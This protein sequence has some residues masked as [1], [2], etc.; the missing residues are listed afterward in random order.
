MKTNL[1]INSTDTLFLFYSEK[2]VLKCEERKLLRMH[3][4][5]RASILGTVYNQESRIEYQDRSGNPCTVTSK[6][7]AL[8][9]R[10]VIFQNEKF[11]PINR[12]NNVVV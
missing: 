9:D 1:K 10:N 7:I 12:I 11:I 4:L 2:D 5:R 6:V 3:D 8:T